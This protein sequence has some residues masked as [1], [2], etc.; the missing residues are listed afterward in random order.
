MT[1]RPSRQEDLARPREGASIAVLKDRCVLLVKR[2]RAPFAGLWSLPGGKT[3]A[4]E[5]PRDAVRRELKEETGIEADIEGVVDTVKIVPDEGGGSVTYR[6]TVFYGRPRGGSLKAGGDTEAAQ[7][8]H[9]DDVEEL[10]MT[11][12]T[13]DLI[14]VAAHRMRSA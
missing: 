9:L 11:P 8:V 2:A 6:L 13:A 3:D 5:A 10:P 4:N 12:G 7:W 14:W 1:D